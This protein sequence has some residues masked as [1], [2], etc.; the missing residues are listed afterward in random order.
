M[1]ILPRTVILGFTPDK[2]ND[3][4]NW[5]IERQS[6]KPS[7]IQDL[8]KS[9]PYLH[10]DEFKSYIQDG[11]YVPLPQDVRDQIFADTGLRNTS[12]RKEI[13]DCK[14]VPYLLVDTSHHTQPLNLTQV[15]TLLLWPKLP[16]PSGG[17]KICWP[18]YVNST[19]K[20]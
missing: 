7:E 18:T 4:Q 14:F 1:L 3:N 12:W 5:L 6:R 15:T 13:F 20:F 16:L 17:T 19:V 2:D 9:S 11:S 10:Q 8:L